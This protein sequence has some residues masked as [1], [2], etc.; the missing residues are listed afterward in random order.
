MRE[1]IELLQILRDEVV[2]QSAVGCLFGLCSTLD[3]LTEA[4]V[5]DPDESEFLHDLIYEHR[6]EETLSP[7]GYFWLRSELK[8]RLEFIDML[9]SLE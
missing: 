3:D 4:C 9:I 1:T 5:L 2:H 8:P 7:G 6:P